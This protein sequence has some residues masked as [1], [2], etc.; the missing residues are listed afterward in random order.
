M[1]FFQVSSDKFD[2]ER[3]CEGYAPTPHYLISS[4]MSTTFP[5]LLA[6]AIQCHI[7][8]MYSFHILSSNPILHYELHQIT[9]TSHLIKL[10]LQP[11]AK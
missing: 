6:Y 8:V 3:R 11:P 1:H 10:F 5:L 2:N 9:K 7:D 4:H